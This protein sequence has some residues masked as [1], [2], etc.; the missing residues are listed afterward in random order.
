[1]YIYIYTYVSDSL[2]LYV[3]V[4]VYIY[5]YIYTHIHMYYYTYSCS[6]SVVRPRRLRNDCFST[7]FVKRRFTN[8][9]V[10]MFLPNTRNQGETLLCLQGIP[11]FTP[12]FSMF[13][14]SVMPGK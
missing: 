2:S 10:D 9:C 12:P 6:I 1:M 14:V 13:S 3:Y 11:S 4:Y 8:A 7:V 5:I